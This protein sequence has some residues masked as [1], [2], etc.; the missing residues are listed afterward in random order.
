MYY[1]C[2]NNAVYGPYTEDQVRQMVAGGQVTAHT[3]V[4]EQGGSKQQWLAASY[5]PGL[6]RR[7]GAS[8]V[9]MPNPLASIKM[10][11]GS[12]DVTVWQGR[13]STWGLLQRFVR[14]ALLLLLLGGV[15]IFLVPRI[16]PDGQVYVYGALGGLTLVLL[17]WFSLELLVLKTR[18]WVLTSQRLCWREGVLCR[19]LEN[20]E[21]YRIKDIT[22]RKP[23]LMRLVGCGYIDYATA[24]V[25]EQRRHVEVGPIHKPDDFYGLFRKY[26]ERE[27]AIHGVKGV[28]H[29]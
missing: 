5:F 26:V 29:L 20:L 1:V 15:S 9:V 16:P 12:M 21:L 7:P 14:P 3:Q 22:L 4:F 25:S 18:S 2:L 23:L 28:E 27:R 6:F 13:P 17:L 19:T 8:G 24:D 11:Q 10:T